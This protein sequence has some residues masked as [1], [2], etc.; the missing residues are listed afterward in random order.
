MLACSWY[1]R[2]FSSASASGAADDG[3]AVVEDQDV[4]RVAPVRR[5]AAADVGDEIAGDALVRPEDKDALGM[6]RG[7][8]AAPGR[9]AGLIQH[10][11]PLRRR[12]GQMNSV[13]LI[14]SAVMPHAMD[15]GGIGENAI[16]LVA[17]HRAVLPA[18][19]P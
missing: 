17:P 2:Y 11:R 16:G 13:D 15:L 7:E 3:G 10:R 4:A 9:R 8:L 5:R 1:S 14:M 18:R 19:L 6:R 12:L